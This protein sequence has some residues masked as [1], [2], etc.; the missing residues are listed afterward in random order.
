MFSRG[1]RV[2]V[3]V[4]QREY[5]AS[6]DDHDRTKQAAKAAMMMIHERIRRGDALAT[7]VRHA[8]GVS[9]AEI[10]LD[11]VP[12][13]VRGVGARDVVKDTGRSL[14]VNGYSDVVDTGHSWAIV[15]CLGVEPLRRLSFEE[16][17][18]RLQHRHIEHAF[19]AHVQDLV[20]RAAVEINRDVYEQ[21]AVD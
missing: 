4:T 17:K 8:M 16:A 12:G 5:L 13:R 18:S 15:H 9:V 2:R 10:A 21:L 14:D 6:D 3:E 1:R 7:A 11:D 19:E 20:D